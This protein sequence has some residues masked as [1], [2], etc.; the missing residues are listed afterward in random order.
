MTY[1]VRSYQDLLIGHH[2]E[3]WRPDHTESIP[4][5]FKR[6]FGPLPGGS[7]CQPQE[8][9]SR[10]PLRIRSVCSSKM[11]T[12]LWLAGTD[13]PRKTRRSV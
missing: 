12:T 3:L 13:S 8:H 7:R 1:L 11:E 5:D 6:H 2:P 4:V 9:L 10:P